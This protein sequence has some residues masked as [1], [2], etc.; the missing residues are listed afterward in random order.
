VKRIQRAWELLPDEYQ[1]AC[2]AVAAL[3]V[4]PLVIKGLPEAEAGLWFSFQGLLLFVNLA[5]FGLSFV[6][7]W[8]VS[9][10]LRARP[11]QVLE[12]TDFITTRSG[13]AGVSDVY[14]AN[15]RL[16]QWVALAGVAVIVLIYH[17]IVPLGR[18]LP[19]ATSSTMLA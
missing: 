18:L 5:D 3:V 8:Q 16:F 12:R 11:G 1:Q 7:A 15:C 2:A 14:A 17:L 13:W 6:V 10:T 4:V 19:S 9:Y